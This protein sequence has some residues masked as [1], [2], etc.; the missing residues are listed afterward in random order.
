MTAISANLAVRIMGVAGSLSLAVFGIGELEDAVRT[1]TW[2]VG[3]FGCSL[4]I[5]A[6][7]LFTWTL[8]GKL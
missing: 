4:L 1:S 5:F 3:A 6:Y 8:Q 7:R 2:H